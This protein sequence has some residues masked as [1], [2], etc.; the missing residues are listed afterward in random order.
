MEYGIKELA[1]LAGVST[2][3]LRY[4]D[5]VGLLK[6]AYV[7]EAG[8]RKYGSEQVDALQHI[9]FFR[10]L[11]VPLDDIRTIMTCKDFD[12][13]AVLEE[14]REALINKRE[15]L[16]VLIETVEKTIDSIR[17]ELIMKDTEKFEAFKQE[18]I[19]ENDRA[20]GSEVCERW[21]QDVYAQS[22]QKVKSMTPAQWAE[23][24]QLSDEVN[25]AL[26]AALAEGNPAGELAQKAC[27]LHRQWLCY[28]WPEGMYSPQ[29]HR[30][31]AEMYVADERFKAHYD[32][33]APGAAEFLCEAI[34]LRSA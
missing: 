19:D 14:H 23:V 1:Q 29:A 20:Y 12:R 2:R 10:E 32:A 4:Y 22:Q 7:T 30:G 8:Y 31:L 6:P 15:R 3:T 33:I 21:G 34:S 11:D 17:G 26:A 16:N 25:E 18:I 5:E 13:M 27:D 24:T 9:R 28:F